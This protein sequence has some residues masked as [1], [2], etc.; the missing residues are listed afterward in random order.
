MIDDGDRLI[1]GAAGR[2]RLPRIPTSRSIASAERWTEPAATCTSS[3]APGTSSRPPSPLIRATGDDRLLQV[4]TG[5]PTSSANLRPRQRGQAGA[6]RR[7]RGDRAGPG[8]AVPRNRRP[9][10]I[11]TRPASSS[12]SAARAPSAA[13][14]TT[15]TPRPIREQSRVVGHAVRAV[16]LNAGAADLS[17][18][19][20]D[21]ALRRALDRMWDEHDHRAAATS[22]AASA[23]AGRARRSARTSSCRTRAPTP[24]PAPRSAA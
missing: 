20:D 21:P 19:G 8:R 15:R 24:S 11:W 14:T 9:R 10:A 2:R 6:D 23:R 4:A 1:E 13:P 7:P 16:Y 5:S 22:A 17:L 18:E 3:T 12:M